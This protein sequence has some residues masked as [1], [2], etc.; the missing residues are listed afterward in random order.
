MTRHE[1]LG[2]IEIQI[3]EL[4]TMLAA[5]F[6]GIAEARR[7]KQRRRRALALDQRIGHQRR[8]VNQRTALAG[9]HRAVFQ[10]GTHRLLH[11]QT[12]IAGSRQSLADDGAAV[13][14]DQKHVGKRAADI[15]AN[16]IHTGSVQ[17]SMFNVQRF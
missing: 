12:R 16:A 17:G 10:H 13:V 9:F 5:N 3:I 15:D 11:R 1:R 2:E 14:T 8:A 6:H 7:R 4:V